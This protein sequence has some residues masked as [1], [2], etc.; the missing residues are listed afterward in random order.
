MFLLC[1]RIC[2]DNYLKLLSE[3]LRVVVLVVL[4]FFFVSVIISFSRLGYEQLVPVC[5]SNTKTIDGSS[6]L[7]APSVITIRLHGLQQ[8]WLSLEMKLNKQ[9]S[10]NFLLSHSLDFVA[11]AHS[12]FTLV[13]NWEV[14]QDC[15][16]SHF[17]LIS[18][19]F[20]LQQL[21]LRFY[22]SSK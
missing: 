19:N 12:R 9:P 17:K 13:F 2:L 11:F 7:R 3:N 20:C 14:I 4:I 8:G 10:L 1:R 6:G 22:P 5:Y 15:C 18:F 21:E 16:R